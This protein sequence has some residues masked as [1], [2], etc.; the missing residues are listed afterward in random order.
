MAIIGIDLGTTNNLACICQDGK[1]IR[2]PNSLGQALTPSA[3]SIDD[4]GK[5]LVGAVAKERL[6][7][8]PS[9]SAASFKRYMGTNKVFLLAGQSFTPQELSSFILRQLKEDAERFLGEKVT[10]AVISVPAYFNDHQRYATKEAGR[11]AG[12]HVERLVN[13]PSAA[14]LAASQISGKEEGC[15]LVFD[16]GGGTLD[17][18]VV[19]YF[20]NVIEIIAVSGDNHLGGDDFDAIIA[21]RFC[22]L[23]QMDYNHLDPIQQASLLRLAEDCKKQ[24]TS[25]SQA[26]LVWEAGGKSIALTNIELARLCQGIFDRIRQV[27]TNALR[28]SSRLMA[29]IDEIVLVGGSSK[30]PVVSLYLQNFFQRKPCMIGSPDEIVAVGAGIYAGIKERRQ[31]I[32]DLVLTDICPFTLGTNVVNHADANKPILSPLIERNSILPCSKTSHFTNVYDGQ[33]HISVGIFQGE[34]YYCHDNIKLGSIE[35]D[36]LPVPANH[37]DIEVCFSYDINGILEV[38]VTDHQKKQVKKKVLTSDR[39]RMSD[40][41]LNERLEALQAYKLMPPGGIRTRLALARGERL[42]AQLLGPR[43]QQVADA[44]Q[45]LQNAIRTQTDQQIINYLRITEKLFDHLEGL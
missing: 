35:M 30:M 42:F 10:E 29:D 11:L 12:L 24:L 7:S 19:D 13:E 33:T 39:F 41:E 15:Y 9:A 22:S 1:S 8:H 38:E 17:V 45:Q 21:R 43:R 3:V 28:D 34:A 16:F 5:I 20:D 6:I 31:D 23:Q 32:R 36:I 18:S 25:Q 4:D 44:I 14:A 26:E 40:A 2:I 27:I 37:A